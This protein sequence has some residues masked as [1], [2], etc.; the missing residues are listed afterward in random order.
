MRI[1]STLLGQDSG[2]QG[3]Y[4]FIHLFYKIKMRVG[5]WGGGMGKYQ[6]KALPFQQ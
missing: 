6:T 4:L 3:P 2:T 1:M 5:G